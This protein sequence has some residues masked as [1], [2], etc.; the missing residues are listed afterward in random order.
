MASRGSR[1]TD[2][3]DSES[4]EEQTSEMISN[5][6]MTQLLY[7][8]QRIQQLCFHSQD[9]AKKLLSESPQLALALIHAQFVVSG[10]LAESNLLPLT[11]DEVKQA[12]ERIT[13][14]RL[15]ETNPAASFNLVGRVSGSTQDVGLSRKLHVHQTAQS[16][17]QAAELTRL[18]TGLD[19]AILENVMLGVTGSEG[20]VGDLSSMVDILMNLSAEQIALLPE[21]LQRQVLKLLEESL[22]V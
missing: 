16:S 21:S 11:S 9:H 10:K 22:I 14:I 2:G 15:L 13:Q 4:N 7:I 1:P 20:K 3:P 18:L 8:L 19:P 5:L 12:K 6:T 17:D